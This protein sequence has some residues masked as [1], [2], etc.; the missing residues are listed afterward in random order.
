MPF[1]PV[2][3]AIS[4]HF[5]TSA[6]LGRVIALR[7]AEKQAEGWFKGELIWLF[8]QLKQSGKVASWKPEC[9]IGNVPQVDFAI[10][11]TS[12]TAAV[13]VKTALCG[14][15]YAQPQP[16]FKK[17]SRWNLPDY[18][19]GGF[20]LPDIL[21]LASIQI[22]PH[23]YL[24][25][26]AY[27]APASDDWDAMLAKVHEKAGGLSVEIA[28]VDD[29]PQEELSIGWL[30]VNSPVPKPAVPSDAGARPALQTEV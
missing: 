7:R 21:G 18:V 22:P 17:G 13:E 25:V 2:W 29:S 4:A 3:E 12:T 6:S 27:P 30:K 28:R 9:E 14:L 19:T 8:E 16:V 11:L 23:R 20:I 26:F 5:F 10:D 1:S 24:M 15:L